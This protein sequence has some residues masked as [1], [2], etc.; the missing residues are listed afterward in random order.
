MRAERLFFGRTSLPGKLSVDRWK[1]LLGQCWHLIERWKIRRKTQNWHLV[2][3]TSKKL[4]HCLN[5]PVG[6]QDH[7]CCVPKTKM[8][9]IKHAVYMSRALDTDNF[10]LPCESE[11]KNTHNKNFNT[12]LL[13]RLK[14]SICPWYQEEYESSVSIW[15]VFCHPILPTFTKNLLH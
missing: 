8:P 9:Q 10:C 14:L 15:S 2:K 4:Q 1:T 12:A 7:N 13:S 5:C 6:F 11:I 3:D